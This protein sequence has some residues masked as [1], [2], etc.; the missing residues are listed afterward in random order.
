MPGEPDPT[1]TP[2]ATPQPTS[3]PVPTPTPVPSTKITLEIPEGYDD[4]TV[5]IDGIEYAVQPKDGTVT[6]ELPD[7]TAGSAT[8]MRYNEKGAPV[9]MYV[10]TLE[11]KDYA[12]EVTAQ[13]KLTDLLTYHGFSIRITDKS[14]IRFKTGISADLRK[15]LLQ[16][17]GVD[18][19]RLK[20]YG[21]L[22]MTDANRKTYP[23]VVG[24]QKVLQGMAYGT[25]AS[26]IFKDSIYETVDNRYRYTSVL[27][28]MPANQYKVDYAFRGYATL[29]KDERDITIYGPVVAKNIYSLAEQLLRM[30]I[31]EEE[32]DA[33]L[34]KLI[35]D[36]DK[37]YDRQQDNRIRQ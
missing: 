12:Y 28:G 20:E 21:T 13:P 1:P 10:W 34:R 22:I 25:D 4:T 11:Y 23:M 9:G 17:D 18:G 3:T 33:D 6:L 14:G 31:Y 27:V 32:S 29:T 24:G 15:K 36:A 30:K 7:E 5:Y 19:Y 16:T 35:Q 37:Q 2:T 8:V 26:G